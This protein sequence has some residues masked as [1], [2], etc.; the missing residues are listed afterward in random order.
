MK[1]IGSKNLYEKKLALMEL[2]NTWTTYSH[3]GYQLLSRHCFNHYRFAVP[4][5]HAFEGKAADF[6]VS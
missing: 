1:Q 2:I 5:K 3:K 4:F 6:V